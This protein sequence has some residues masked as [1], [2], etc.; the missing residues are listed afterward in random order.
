MYNNETNEPK[1]IIIAD[2]M[3]FF[4]PFL[5][6]LEEISNINAIKKPS[7]IFCIARSLHDLK[8]ILTLPN[9]QE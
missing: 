7:E 3:E 5:N 6:W 1:T 8:K 2:I 9:K 4:S